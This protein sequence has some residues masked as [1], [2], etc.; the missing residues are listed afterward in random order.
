[1]REYENLGVI[2]K[3]DADKLYSLIRAADSLLSGLMSEVT[4]E[5]EDGETVLWEHTVSDMQDNVLVDGD[6]ITGDLYYVAEGALPAVWGPGYFLTLKFDD[7]DESATSVKVGLDPSVSSG[8][9]ALDEDKNAVFKISDRDGQRLK[10]V[11]TDGTRS[12]VQLFDLSGL[13]MI[14]A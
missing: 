3:R 10:V 9:V 13:N 14:P 1:M 5:P 4:V 6:A 8:L 12:T 11:S 7:F 2:M